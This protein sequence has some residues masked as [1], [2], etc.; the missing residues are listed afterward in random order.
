MLAYCESGSN[1]WD[2]KTNA[3]ETRNHRHFAEDAGLRVYVMFSAL[4]SIVCRCKLLK[5]LEK[6]SWDCAVVFFTIA[7]MAKHDTS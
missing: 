3:T 6:V 1:F 7:Q 4:S 5:G 2:W